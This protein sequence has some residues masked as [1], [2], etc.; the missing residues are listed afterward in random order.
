[1][2]VG[3]RNIHRIGTLY[4]DSLTEIQTAFASPEGRAAAADRRLYAPDAS[5]VEMFLFDDKEV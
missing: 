1:M 3:A 2:P 5:G 4:F